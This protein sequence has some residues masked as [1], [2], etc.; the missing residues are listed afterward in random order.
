MLIDGGNNTEFAMGFISRELITARM[1]LYDLPLSI[2]SC[3][4]DISAGNTW[5]FSMCSYNELQ[6]YMNSRGWRS[7]HAIFSF[8]KRQMDFWKYFM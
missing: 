1:A 7:D 2:R 8:L 3:L 6:R 5:T 4:Q